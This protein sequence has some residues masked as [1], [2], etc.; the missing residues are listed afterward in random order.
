MDRRIYGPC[1]RHGPE[2]VLCAGRNGSAEPTQPPGF[3]VNRLVE[4]GHAAGIQEQLWDDI[5]RYILDSALP[6]HATARHT[7]WIRLVGSFP[8]LVWTVL[9][10]VIFWVGCLI[11]RST[12]ESPAEGLFLAACIVAVVLVLREL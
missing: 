4:G 11:T 8:P 5:A 3:V 6:P 10:G 7:G 12:P 2:G 1:H 9:L